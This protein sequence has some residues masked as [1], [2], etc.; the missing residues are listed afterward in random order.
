MRDVEAIR[1]DAEEMDAKINAIEYE[2][3]NR[4]PVKQLRKEL[5]ALKAARLAL[6]QE[7]ADAVLGAA[8]AAGEN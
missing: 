2:I 5:S 3:E 7:A 8:V 6:R 4:K 1:A